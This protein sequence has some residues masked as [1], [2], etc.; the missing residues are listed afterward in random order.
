MKSSGTYGLFV[1]NEL[2]AP[3]SDPQPSISA[4]GILTAFSTRSAFHTAAF[5][6]GGTN[7][8]TAVMVRSPFK[9]RT[10]LPFTDLFYTAIFPLSSIV[11][12]SHA[13]PTTGKSV[14]T[15]SFNS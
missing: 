12:P 6:I 11:C 13:A 14:I 7:F 4:L 3:F 1:K 15:L 5:K 8:L 9:R 10:F 2:A